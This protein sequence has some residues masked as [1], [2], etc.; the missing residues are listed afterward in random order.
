[1]ALLELRSLLVEVDADPERDPSFYDEAR[2]HGV[3]YVCLIALRFGF[4]RS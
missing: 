1:M 4:I 2:L 3:V